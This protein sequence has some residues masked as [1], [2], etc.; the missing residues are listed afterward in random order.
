MHVNV[1]EV[2]TF[3]ANVNVESKGEAEDELNTIQAIDFVSDVHF[4]IHVKSCQ[5]NTVCN[6]FY[7]HNRRR[8]KTH[9]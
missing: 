4:Q 2:C 8:Y 9:H 6:L 7:L 5:R 1:I 3:C